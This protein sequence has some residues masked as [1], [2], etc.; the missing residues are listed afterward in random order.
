M[1]ITRIELR[2]LREPGGREYVVLRAVTDGGLTGWGE[3]PARPDAASALAPLKKDLAS[4]VGMNPARAVRV[5]EELRRAGASP[6]ARAAA[7]LAVLDLYAQSA[8]A[9]LYELLGGTTRHKVR[10]T[11]VLA[12]GSKDEVLAAQAAGYR[13]FSI[14]L[15]VP[16]GPLQVPGDRERGRRFF[17]DVR[18]RMDALRSAAGDGADFI[19]DCAGLTSPGEA[20]SIAVRME[21]F[22]LL[23]LDEPVGDLSVDARASVSR[24]SVTPVGYGRDVADN[25]RF[26]DLLTADAVDVLRPDL[27]LNGVTAVRKAAAIAETYYV[28]VAPYHRGGP[29]GTAA[30]IHAAASLPNSFAQE[31]PFSIDDADRKARTRLAGGWEERPEDGFFALP[32]A[33]G[34]GIRID[35]GALDAMTV[36]R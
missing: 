1:K 7:N 10:A 15:Q 4:L 30:G 3:A 28:A 34:L 11:A 13:A 36:A 22:H 26:Q 6:A 16:G 12:T 27:A 33:P 32:E 31:A 20:L 17:T 19:L 21:D 8:K 29:I 14:P 35:E 18:D 5:D 23:W 25:A 9:P 2:G 24:G